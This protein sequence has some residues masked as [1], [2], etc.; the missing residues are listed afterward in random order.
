MTAQSTVTWLKAVSF[1]TGL[2][3]VPLVFAGVPGLSL[4]ADLFI[5]LAYWPLDG[6]QRITQPETKLLAAIA[7][8]V[9]IGLAT[10]TWMVADRIYAR[11]PAAARAIIL[12]SL[13]AWLVTDSLGSLLA[14]APVNVL[15]NLVIWGAFV[16]PLRTASVESA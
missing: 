5:D 13:S 2:S 1:V 16:W 9:T 8:G 6:Q 4:I 10:F 3:V 12:A 15:I 7:G 14:G 11:D